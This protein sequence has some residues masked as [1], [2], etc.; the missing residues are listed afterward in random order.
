M[1]SIAH[2]STQIPVWRTRRLANTPFFFT[3]MFD[4][5]FLEAPLGPPLPHHQ[6]CLSMVT[7]S[8]HSRAKTKQTTTYV[9]SPITGAQIDVKYWIE[10][11]DEVPTAMVELT[12]PL[13]SATVGHN[14]LHA[15]LGSIAWEVRAL[16]LLVKV[17][18]AVLGFTGEEIARFMK[19]VVC[20]QLEL[21]WHS[22][23]ASTRALRSAQ[24]RSKEHFDNQ[25]QARSLHDISVC[26]IDYREG[27]LKAGI[28]VKLK[29]SNLI[30]QY[31]KADQIASR[32]NENRQQARMSVASRQVSTQI[33]EDIRNDVR[34]EILV[35]GDTLSHFG[36]EHPRTWTVETLKVVIDHV[37]KAAGLAPA[38]PKEVGKLSSV[39]AETWRQHQ[40]GVDMS[41]VLRTHSF[42]RHRAAI[43][44]A[45][46]DDKDIAIPYKTRGVRSAGLGYQLCY[47]RRCEPSAHQRKAV[48]CEVTA[49]AIIEDLKRGLAFIQSGSVPA[50]EDAEERGRWL[51]QWT[52]FV[53]REGGRRHG[54][55]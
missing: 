39:V 12:V 37:W 11:V 3:A 48:L 52:A 41:K 8:R 49:P 17:I 16:A 42:S 20:V 34:N 50:I 55:E 46:G 6:A 28:F 54:A 38:Q 25:F 23:T 19:D 31:G 5:I 14:Y 51:G 45:L 4:K 26:S 32:K 40:A 30:R 44:R 18:L 10:V 24:N 9:N 33:V 29:D 1:T 43:K 27:D 47:D 15:G 22:R 35:G 21:T 7:Y 13:S 53:T 2:H 36:M